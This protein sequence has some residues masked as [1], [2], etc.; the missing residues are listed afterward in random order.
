[1]TTDNKKISEAVE[2]ALAQIKTNAPEE[3]SKLIADGKLK[4]AI[5]TAAR[6]AADE[7]VKLAH[8][9]A[10]QPEQ[11]IRKRLE[12]HL[13]EDRIRLIEK[14]LTI[15]TFRMEISKM[16][17]GK[18]L[19]QLTREGEEFLPSRELVVS[20][21]IVWATILQYASVVV[22]AVMLVMQA[23]GIGVSVS[24]ST[25]KATIEDTAEAIKKSSAFQQAIQKFV[26]SWKAAGGSATNKA[27]AIFF[28]LKE[29]KA[30]GLLWTIIK[31]LCKEMSKWDWMKTA[32]KVSAMIIAAVA[33][34]GAAL[35]AKIALTV[36]A[37]VDFARKIANLV[38][39]EEIKKSLLEERDFA[40]FGSLPGFMT[41]S[42]QKIQISQKYIE[43][44]V[45]NCLVIHRNRT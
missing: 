13:P 30:A 10:S 33:T 31:S 41:F 37:A 40:G 1:M 34:E 23:V 11:D 4:D 21:D 25:M 6:E 26:S 27:K 2:G 39:L 36:L 17:N 45:L 44:V 38:Q 19:V 9:F 18:H 14:A 42:D 32:A 20:A 7:E 8:E 16:D 29:I 43:K 35:I 12:K 15:P 22:E 28:L 3:H 24:S 5:T